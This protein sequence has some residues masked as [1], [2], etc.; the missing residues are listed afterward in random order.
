[1]F[2]RLCRQHKPAPKRG[3]TIRAFVEVGA[4]T[5]RKDYLERHITTE[6]HQ[7]SIRCQASLVSGNFQY[8]LI[9]IIIIKRIIIII[10]IP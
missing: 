10:I 3:A 2:C 9:Y 6:H 5:Y 4:I 7:E 1:M 8:Q